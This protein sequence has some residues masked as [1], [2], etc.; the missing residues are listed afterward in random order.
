MHI[1]FIGQK[2][3]PAQNPSDTSEKRV[4]ALVSH[5]SQQ[6]HSVTV[7]CERGYTPNSLR[8]IQTAQLYRPRRLLPASV[9]ILWQIW[10]QRPDVIHIQNWKAAR[11]VR[12]AV[13]LSPESTYVWT[14]SELPKTWRRARFTAWLNTR[15]FDAITTPGRHLQYLLLVQ[16]G[17]RVTY[18]PDGYTPSELPLIPATAW[19][20]RKNQYA[21]T[22]ASTP[23]DVEWIAQTYKQLKTRKKLVTVGK[24][25]EFA[26]LKRKYPFLVNI[27]S[28]GNRA[29][30]SLIHQATV[31]IALSADEQ[32]L[33]AMH[34]QRPIIAVASPALEE[35]VGTTANI[36]MQGDSDT[37]SGLLR[38]TLKK[39][40]SASVLSKKAAKRAQA[41]FRWKRIYEEYSTLYHYPTTK[42]IPLDSV[43]PRRHV[44]V[45]A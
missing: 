39:A 18:I 37:L 26:R 1:L 28:L 7:V 42:R 5:L 33:Q 17:L 13:L 32:L 41:H 44:A 4:E 29:V 11:L 8:F 19:K 22:T 21:L 23:K 35:I 45:S 43:V 25:A 31:V 12:F 9:G 6:G 16:L 30:V 3:L 20:L 38:K 10:R 15:A 24:M 34:G 2:G 27:N 14:I 36:V 40:D